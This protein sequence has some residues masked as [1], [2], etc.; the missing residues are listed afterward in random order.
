ML[1]FFS[2]RKFYWKKPEGYK[3]LNPWLH[4]KVK[5]YKETQT[6]QST[7]PNF[8]FACPVCSIPRR[9]TISTYCFVKQ[10]SN[11][12]WQPLLSLLLLSRCVMSY[13]N[14]NKSRRWIHSPRDGRN[15]EHWPSP[16]SLARG[17]LKTKLH[18]LPLPL[19]SPGTTSTTAGVT[20]L[21]NRG[22]GYT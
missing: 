8:T 14:I 6:K 18:L 3:T 22:T 16:I 21:K 19:V 12:L 20:G 5:S 2:S 7:P 10:S 9:G 15:Q 17:T 1:G 11:K 13:T 4:F